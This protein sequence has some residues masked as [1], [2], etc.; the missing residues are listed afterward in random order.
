M[1][2]RLFFSTHKLLDSTLSGAYTS[3]HFLSGVY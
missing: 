3:L 2:L 1:N